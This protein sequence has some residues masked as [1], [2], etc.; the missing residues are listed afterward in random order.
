MVGWRDSHFQLIS[1][2]Y[3]AAHFH[4]PK[5]YSPHGGILL[6]LNSSNFLLVCIFRATKTI[7]A[8]SDTVILCFLDNNCTTAGYDGH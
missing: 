2:P 4:P 3:K 6:A 7:P 8:F 5:N 1:F